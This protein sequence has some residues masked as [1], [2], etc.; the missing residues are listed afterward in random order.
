MLP[1]HQEPDASSDEIEAALS[2]HQT[3]MQA[4][5]EQALANALTHALV[6][7]AQAERHEH[8]LH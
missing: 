2:A 5:F 6:A 7:Q 4:A 3:A 1:I 8:I